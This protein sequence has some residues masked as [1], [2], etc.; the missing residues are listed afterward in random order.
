MTPTDINLDESLPSQQHHYAGLVV[1]SEL[2]RITVFGVFWGVF[3]GVFGVFLGC[4]WVH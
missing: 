1:L 2:A 4:F 3:W